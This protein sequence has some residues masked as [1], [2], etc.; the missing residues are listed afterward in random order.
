MDKLQQEFLRSQEA[1]HVVRRPT[2]EH[3]ASSTSLGLQD[4]SSPSPS[5]LASPPAAALRDRP[6]PFVSHAS[7]A[8]SSSRS[9]APPY[10]QSSYE[11]NP[12]EKDAAD[13]LPAMYQD[14]TGAAPLPDL[15]SSTSHL[16]SSVDYHSSDGGTHRDTWGE[17]GQWNDGLRA[18]EGAGPYRAQLS[19]SRGPSAWPSSLPRP[20]DAHPD[21]VD[22]YRS[23][24]PCDGPL[25]R[26]ETRA[27]EV[28]RKEGT[29]AAW[30]SHYLDLE[31]RQHSGLD[32]S[33]SFAGS[34]TLSKPHADLVE[35]SPEFGLV[36]STSRR[37]TFRTMMASLVPP[38]IPTR[39]YLGLVL[40]Q[41]LIVLAMLVL[42]T[43]HYYA[44][45]GTDF[46]FTEADAEEK[47]LPVW[48]GIF[49]LAHAWLFGMAV[50]GLRAR[51][52]IQVRPLSLTVGSGRARG[53]DRLTQVCATTV[54]RSSACRSST[55]PCS[56][57]PSSRSRRFEA[58]S[59]FPRTTTTRTRL[60]CRRSRLTS[61]R[62][63][64]RRR[65]ASA[66][67]GTSSSTGSS[68]ASLGGRRTRRSA[69]IGA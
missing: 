12:N 68:T 22:A 8:S 33:T 61:C 28:E 45:E 62:R 26:E 53:V 41:S 65:S 63:S 42:L 18:E 57:T 58:S 25:Y 39:L 36:R 20:N 46:K 14:L 66:R 55:S 64:S 50:E 11:G 13:W 47:R 2:F 59:T 6:P 21:T 24:R 67:S 37:G 44:L 4:D 1:S 49:A 15:Y 17:R 19:P 10:H 16:S 48:L 43:L 35:M 34:G 3:A 9:D 31:P 32:R 69:R 40:L 7:H 60:A 38:S 52:V 56:P 54:V 23:R 5:Y 30:Q 29:T 51:N 27:G